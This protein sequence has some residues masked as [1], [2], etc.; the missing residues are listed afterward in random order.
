MTCNAVAWLKPL[1]SCTTTNKGYLS[2]CNSCLQERQRGSCQGVAELYKDVI[3][4][5]VYSNLMNYEVDVSQW[6]KE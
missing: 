1:L 6:I 4:P 5:D 2:A 3:H